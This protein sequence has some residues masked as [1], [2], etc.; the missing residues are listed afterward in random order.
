MSVPFYI[1]AALAL[2]SAVSMVMQRNPVY[3]ALSLLVT[4][5][6]VA[7][8]FLTLHAPFLAAIHIIVYTGA[9]LVLFL[10]VIMLLNLQE[11]EFG[12]EHP[13]PV[14]LSIAAMSA[15]MFAVLTITIAGDPSVRMPLPSPG[16]QD[17]AYTG[18]DGAQE[19]LTT[20]FG[21]VEHVGLVLFQSYG[22]PFELVSALIIVAMLGAVVLAKKR[23][24]ESSVPFEPQP[25]PEHEA[26][27]G[28][29]H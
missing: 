27:G 20:D 11:H 16:P 26:P 3:S 7:V 29:G 18:P 9:I 25:E 19:I 14:R 17:V 23:L 6:S 8:I 21:S 5:L 2:A 4:F 1:A 13:P 10:F 12:A 24:P 28:G 22:L 15:A